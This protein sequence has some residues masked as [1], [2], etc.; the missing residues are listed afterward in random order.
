[1]RGWKTATGVCQEWRI[2]SGVGVLV[3]Y[4]RSGA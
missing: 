3:F 2:E 4:S 1:M